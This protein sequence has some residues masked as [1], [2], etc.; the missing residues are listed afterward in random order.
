[1]PTT[2]NLSATCYVPLIPCQ[3]FF[4]WLLHPQ[5]LL[6][7]YTCYFHYTSSCDI[8]WF[9]RLETVAIH[10]CSILYFGNGQ[11]ICFTKSIFRLVTMTCMPIWKT[12]YLVLLTTGS[13]M[14]RNVL[15]RSSW[16]LVVSGTRCI[17]NKIMQ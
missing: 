12:I 17:S 1:M 3:L 10:G 7:P 2:P 6:C 4:S 13:L 11:I 15:V 9:E 14:H 8:I 5:C 16:L